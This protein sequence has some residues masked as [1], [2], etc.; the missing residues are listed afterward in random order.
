M[1]EV[2]RSSTIETSDL[3]LCMLSL[4]RIKLGGACQFALVSPVRSIEVLIDW[5]TEPGIFG[6]GTFGIN[7]VG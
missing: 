5:G 2:A 3:V 7:H 1:K 4:Q 6:P